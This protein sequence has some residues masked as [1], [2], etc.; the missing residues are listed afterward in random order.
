[1][2]KID[3][4]GA[5]IGTIEEA[6]LGL[7]KAS[8]YP[9]LIARFKATKKFV[10]DLPG[11]EFFKITEPAWVDWTANDEDILGYL[12]LFK[13]ADTFDKETALLNYD[14]LQV[15]TGWD[16]TSFDDLTNG[17]LI[18]KEVLFRVEEGTAEYPN[19]KVNWIDAPDAAPER[20]LKAIDTGILKQLNSKLKFTK[21]AKPVAAAKPAA[22]KP[23]AAA[24]TY[25][26]GKPSAPAPAASAG[27]P[28]ATPPAKT[29][30]SKSVAAKPPQAPPA[31]S[32]GL[33][34]GC[35]DE[36]GYACIM[37]ANA[38]ANS[39][40]DVDAAWLAACDEVVEKTQVDSKA[41]TPEHWA[42]V[43]NLTL[44]DLDL[45]PKLR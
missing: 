29:P 8:G 1:M 25:T 37:E 42:Q 23:A 4:A 10:S 28:A 15:A 19:P 45:K 5:Y 27:S 38:G 44:K 2:V 43:R 31:E 12:V 20:T 14:Q 26:T 21:A 32:L 40:S 34:T 41:F 9:Q 6:T 13:S 17:K 30:P 22:T 11:M 33:P 39:A 36:E 16:G 24:P 35:T 3:T 7:T 18:G